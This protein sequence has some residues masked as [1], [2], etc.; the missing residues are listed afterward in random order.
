[1]PSPL[2]T[3]FLLWLLMAAV[4]FYG[5]YC[6]RRPHLAAPWKRVFQ[7]KAAMVSAV[8]LACYVLI[9]FANWLPYGARLA[10]PGTSGAD[11]PEVLSVLAFC[12]LHLRRRFH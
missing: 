6:S 8:I 5:W 4:A 11:S 10:R 1:M 3:D 2:P 7:S 9:G 12:L